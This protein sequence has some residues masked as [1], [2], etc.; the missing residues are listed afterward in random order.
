[1]NETSIVLGFGWWVNKIAI[2]LD[3]VHWKEGRARPSVFA[4]ILRRRFFYQRASR[5]DTAICVVSLA[6][7]LRLFGIDGLGY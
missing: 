2:W 7:S 3:Q 4:M 6:L 1:M 5:F